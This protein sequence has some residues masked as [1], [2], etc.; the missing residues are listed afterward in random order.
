MLRKPSAAARMVLDAPHPDTTLLPLLLGG[1]ALVSLYADAMDLGRHYHTGQIM[2]VVLIAGIF[3]GIMLGFLAPAVGLWLGNALDR[4]HRVQ[5]AKHLHIPAFPL[6]NLVWKRL[7]GA[8][9]LRAAFSLPVMRQW[10]LAWSALV[11]CIQY[12]RQS[13]GGGIVGYERLVVGFGQASRVFTPAALIAGFVLFTLNSPGFGGELASSGWRWLGLGAEVLA[14]AAMGLI[15][16]TMLREAFLLSWPKAVMAGL[17]SIVGSIGAVF[18]V[19]AWLTD[20]KWM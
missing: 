7:L 1:M 2:S 4:R 9:R 16:M 8:E 19:L 13:L 17:G 12:V 18:A 11:N 3:T 5:F 14:L 20:I 15:W 6:K 10:L